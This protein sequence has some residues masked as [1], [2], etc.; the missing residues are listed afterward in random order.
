MYKFDHDIYIQAD[1]IPTGL[2]TSVDN[3][4]ITMTIWLRKVED[5][6]LKNSV[7]LFLSFLYVDD[8]RYFGAGFRLGLTFDPV[9]KQITYSEDQYIQDVKDNLDVTKKSALMLKQIMNSISK[10]IQVT[11]ES[12]HDFQNRKLPNLH[13][14][15]W[16]G[17]T[18]PEISHTDGVSGSKIWYEFYEKP[19][20]SEKAI[21]QSSAMSYNM[22]RASLTQ[23]VHRRLLNTDTELPQ[24]SKNEIINK[25]TEKLEKSGYL[26]DQ[27]WDITASG[28]VGYKRK[29]TER[30]RHRDQ[31]KK[32]LRGL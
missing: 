22:K 28:L 13:F 6:L 10:G 20:G 9:S 17:D 21:C 27:I 2:S 14:Q 1:G 25:F 19:M 7:N 4:K 5:T 8:Y 12:V 29:F 30:Q 11:T 3:S 16:V 18:E 26:R 15:L 32:N 23:E 24:I 31:N